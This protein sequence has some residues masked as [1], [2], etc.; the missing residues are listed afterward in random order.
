MDVEKHAAKVVSRKSSHEH[1]WPLL[2]YFTTGCQSKKGSFS[3]QPPLLSAS[4]MV[5]CHH[6]CPRVSLYTLLL[7]HSVPVQMGEKIFLVQDKN[8]R[9]LVTGRSLFRL[10]LSGT[11]FLLTSDIAVLSHSSK[12]LLKL[13]SLLLPTLIYS[14]PFT[15]IGCCTWFDLDFAA[16][17]FTSWLMWVLCC[18]FGGSK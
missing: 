9:A 5:P 18:C 16:D 2:K 14:N 12:L 1:V 15:G 17:V 10:P 13:F 11:T 6:T 8:L 7:A 4:L 3:R